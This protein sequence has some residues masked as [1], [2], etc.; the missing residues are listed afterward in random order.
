MTEGFFSDPAHQPFDLGVG[1]TRALLIPGFM[2]TPKEM[3][4]LG[5]ALAEAGVSARGILL[6]GFGPDLGRLGTV[7]VADWLR[8]AGDAWDQV[9]AGAQGTALVGFS[10]GGAVALHLAARR[11][12]DRLVLIAPHWRFAD[13]RALALPLLK[14]VLRA[15]RP[16]ANAD[17]TEPR[18]R[19]S[20]AEMAPGADLEDPGVQARLRRET[21]LPTATLNELRRVSTT[22][23]R[24]A[25]RVSAPTLVLQ[26]RDDVTVLPGDTR[27]LAVRL[28]GALALRELPGGH[29]LV[30]DDGPSW[31]VV[32]ALVT[33]FV[34]ASGDP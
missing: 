7:R 24:A 23:G 26:G 6:P 2:G 13:R 31:P 5:Q 14:Q 25:R 12:P 20:F 27:R 22:A 9:S 33:D 17:F 19:Q 34:T 15:F 32:R 11:P 16:F 18:V 29:L 21:V 28:G 3:R 30:A 10:M 1:T 8:A 4:P